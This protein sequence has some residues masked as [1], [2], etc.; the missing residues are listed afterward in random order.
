MSYPKG[1]SKYAAIQKA[2]GSKPETNAAKFAARYKFAGQLNS[3][4]L[5]DFG[6]EAQETYAVVLRLSLAYS[7]FEQLEA[8]LG[9]TNIAIV[10]ADLANMLR[11]APVTK[12]RD[13]LL[14]ESRESLR[15]ELKRFFETPGDNNLSPVYRAIRHAMFHGS[16]NPSRSGLTSKTS[17]ILVLELDKSLFK[18][19][20]VEFEKYLHSLP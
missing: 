2:L 6:A 15:K 10:R 17:R 14:M 20:D 13:F 1:Y 3:I 9:R 8:L 4:E 5:L 12:F 7:A 16:L 11:S 18:F 19:M